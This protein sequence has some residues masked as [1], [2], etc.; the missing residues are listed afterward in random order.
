MATKNGIRH[1]IGRRIKQLRLAKELTIQELAER[2]KMSAGYLSE[3]ER[4][5][6]ALSA[7]KLAALARCL[8]T[9]VDYLLTGTGGP[10]EPSET[11]IP[12]GLANAA[13]TLDLSYAQTVRLLAGKQSLVAARGPERDEWT[14]QN[15]IDF[16]N[17][18]E[19]YL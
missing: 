16:Y 14:V 18:V 4:A 6:S 11:R 15:W 1:E 17:K 2:A 7:E 8:D 19:P 10:N 13:Q 9:S 5:R 3:V 12:A